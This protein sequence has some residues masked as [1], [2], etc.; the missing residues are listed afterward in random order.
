[1]RV[2]TVNA[3]SSS[4]KLSLLDG[5]QLVE[6]AELEATGGQ[7]DATELRD[8]LARVDGTDAVAHRVVHGGTKFTTAVVVDEEVREALEHLADLAP[9]HQPTSLAALDTVRGALPD[10]PA[11]AC[12]DTAFFADLPA[13]AATLA[14]PRAWRERYALRRFGFHGLSHAWASRRGAE[15]VSGRHTAARVVVAHLGSGCSLSAV[16]GGH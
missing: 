4:L 16:R 12:F 10:V 8:F 9:L 6:S 11:V 2:L 15:L 5:E 13:A 14:L 1:M 3:G 7:A